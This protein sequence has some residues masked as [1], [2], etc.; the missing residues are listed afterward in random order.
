MSTTTRIRRIAIANRGEIARRIIRTC[1]RLGIETVALFSDV[2]A[3]APFV[4]EATHSIA[5]G[6][7]MSYLSIE[8]ILSAARVSHA[9]AIHPGYGFLSEN[10]DFAQAIHDAGMLFIGPRAATI[11]ALGS[12]TNAKELAQRAKVPTSPTLLLKESPEPILVDA[13]R[14]FGTSVGFP[15][16]IK[17]AAG[18]GGRGMRILQTNSDIASELASARR[19]AERSFKSGEVFIEKYIAPARH[20]E[21]QIAADTSGNVVAL[22]TRDCSLQRN[23]QKIIEEAPADHLRSGVSAAMC[24]AACRLAREAQYSNLGTVEFLYLADGSFFFL[25]V[26][27]RLQVEHPVTEMITGLDLVELQIRIAQGERLEALGLE[28]SPESCGHA[29][30]ARL[31]AEE[32]VGEFTTTTGVVLDL[33]IPTSAESVRADMAVTPCSIVSHHYDSLLGKII[34]HGPSRAAAIKLLTTTLA[35]VRLS[36]VGNNRALLIHLLRSESFHSLS[37]SVQETLN[38]L[39]SRPAL[40]EEWIRAHVVAAI[41]RSTKAHS[42]WVSSSPWLEHQAHLYAEISIPYTTQS[43][44]LRIASLTRRLPEGFHVSIKSP[45]PR[46]FQVAVLSSDS[47]HPYHHHIELLVDGCE[48]IEATLRRDHHTVWVHLQSGTYQLDDQ[49]DTARANYSDAEL[50]GNR[51]TSPL[52]GKISSLVVQEG[53]SITAGDLLIVLDSMKMEHPVRAPVS[54]ILVSIPVS[55]GALVQSGSLLAII[56]E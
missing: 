53:Q 48:R 24:A 41:Y 28:K 46:A 26:N 11:R 45:Y 38:L 5:L 49:P 12:K 19:E 43:Y 47:R 35:R 30:E 31:C 32:F 13:I 6:G 16:L 40:E 34:A 25:E 52:P 3:E 37:H 42:T 1:N 33:E 21:V 8:A 39:P 56:K 54:G 17:A 36:G 7:P 55:I 2:D 15:I 4:S 29:I 22:S 18:G 51:I 27:T 50:A 10:P 14:E 23:N 44:H 9:D 20:I